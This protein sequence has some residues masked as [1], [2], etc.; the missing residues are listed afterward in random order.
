MTA[1]PRAERIFSYLV[2]IMIALVII[3]F[4]SAALYLPDF[5]YP[6]APFLILHAL[7]ALGWYVLTAVQANLIGRGNYQLHMKL[8]GGSLVLAL[9]MLVTGYLVV[10]GAVTAPSFSI[11]GMSVLG[12][13]IFPTIDLLLFA[14][15]YA[16]GVANRKNGAAH[17]RLM[18]MAGIVMLPPATARLGMVVGFEPLAGVIALVLT[19]ALIIYDWRTRGR[20]HWASV[21]GLIVAVGVIPL[22]FV[23][24]PS[25]GWA[26][27]AA[28]LYQ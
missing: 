2:W 6:P 20:P 16:L 14:L 1:N 13:T 8:G 23:V 9:A 25:E 26:Q 22:Q 27:V 3:G 19:G 12:S 5:P 4:G 10:R 21:L 28:A 15:F 18:I 7:I 17:K 11:A 24:G